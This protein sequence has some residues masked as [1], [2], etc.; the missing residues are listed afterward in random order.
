MA[1]CCGSDGRSRTGRLIW[2][3]VY[4]AIAALVLGLWAWGRQPHHPEVGP[5]GGP[6]ADWNSGAIR[7]EVVPDRDAGAVTV[8]ALDRWAEKPK[9]IDAGA[10]ALTLETDPGTVVRLE[11]A[12]EAGDPAGRSSRFMGRHPVFKVEAKLVGTVSGTAGGKSY[13]GDLSQK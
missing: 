7:L 12:P 2:T 4:F 6:L 8:Y 9:P 5:H 13:S 3:G 10:L 1:G 11:P